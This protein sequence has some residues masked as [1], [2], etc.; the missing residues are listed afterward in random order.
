MPLHIPATSFVVFAQL[1]GGTNTTGE[2]AAWHIADRDARDNVVMVSGFRQIDTKETCMEFAKAEALR[3]NLGEPTKIHGYPVTYL[4]YA[5]Q[6][7]SYSCARIEP[8]AAVVA[9][10]GPE[11]LLKE[12]GY[13]FTYDR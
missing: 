7:V 10:T 8:A 13:N 1:M 4:Q 11:A 3:L 2:E 12:F 9:V 6:D 5:E